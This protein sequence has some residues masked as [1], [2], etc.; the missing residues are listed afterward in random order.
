VDTFAKATW[1]YYLTSKAVFFGSIFA[2]VKLIRLNA[3]FFI[4]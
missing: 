1:R 4:E 2:M 3:R